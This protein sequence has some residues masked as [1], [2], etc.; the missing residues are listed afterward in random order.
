MKDS[1]TYLTLVRRNAKEMTNE[2][3]DS[4][5]LLNNDTEELLPA[6]VEDGSDVLKPAQVIYL[7]V[8]YSRYLE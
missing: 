7:T 1:S 2:L 6:R 8:H 4:I 3:F 5:L